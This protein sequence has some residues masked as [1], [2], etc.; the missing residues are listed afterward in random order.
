MIIA[1]ACAVAIAAATVTLLL[2]GKYGHNGI[3][4]VKDE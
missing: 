4:W 3:V 2:W 1:I